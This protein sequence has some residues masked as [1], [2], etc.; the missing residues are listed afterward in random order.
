MKTLAFH[1]KRFIAVQLSGEY[2]SN[3]IRCFVDILFRFD[4]N[5]R[6]FS[7]DYEG[8]VCQIMQSIPQRDT[9]FSIDAEKVDDWYASL[10]IFIDLLYD[11]AIYFKT[12]PG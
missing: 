11:E 12:E 9:F 2:L 1:L 5:Y 8:K 3:I 7:L 10:K 6:D 4:G